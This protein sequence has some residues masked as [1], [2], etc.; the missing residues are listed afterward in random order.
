MEH[1]TRFI[2]LEDLSEVP[3]GIRE[4]L[5]LGGFQK[6]SWH[7]KSEANGLLHILSS[8][9][10]SNTMGSRP[11]FHFRRRTGLDSSITVSTPR[12]DHRYAR[13]ILG[14]D[15][16]AVYMQHARKRLSSANF[17]TLFSVTKLDLEDHLEEQWNAGS[18]AEA[19]LAFASSCSVP[20]S[21]IYNCSPRILDKW[22]WFGTG[23]P[24]GEQD[25][26]LRARVL[27]SQHTE[28][29]EEFNSMLKGIPSIWFDRLA[30]K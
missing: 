5:D 16:P 24:M 29:E 17:S 23:A 30:G 14:L 22:F 28:D 4:G 19:Y 11:A 10:F 21:M 12:I 9:Y 25:K 13:Y 27:V 7:K 15:G 8:Y 26:E 18:L 1:S 3:C 6:Y 2:P 20:L